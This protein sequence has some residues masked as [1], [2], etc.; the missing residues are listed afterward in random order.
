MDRLLSLRALVVVIVVLIGGS[1]PAAGQSP[2]DLDRRALRG[3]Y[4]VEAAAFTGLMRTVDASFY[5]AMVGAPVVAWS[6]A[7]GQTL[8]G[9]DGDFGAAYRLTVTEAGAVALVFGMKR[10]VRRPRPYEA[11]PDIRSRSGRLQP[12]EVLDPYAFPSGH[13]TLSFA[14]ATSITLSQPRWYVAVPTYMWAT[15]VAT[16]R[17]WLGVHYPS[18]VLVGAL[19]GTAVGVAVHQARDALTPGVL[20]R[21]AEHE[22]EMRLFVLRWSLGR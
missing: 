2:A 17:V 12:G 16:S 7:G 9:Y 3:V 14:L 8:A 18:D 15:S 20:K 6:V 10:L 5:P 1:A 13:A 22:A 19:L 4:G 21:D 11:L